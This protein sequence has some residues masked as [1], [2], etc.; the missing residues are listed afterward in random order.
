MSIIKPFLFF[1]FLVVATCSHAKALI[2]GQDIPYFYYEDKTNSLSLEL[3]LSLPQ[4]NL[5][6]SKKTLSK[7]YT[8]STFWIKFDVNDKAF[9]NNEYWFEVLPVYLDRIEFYY[10][11][12]SSN[13]WIKRSAG[14]LNNAAEWDVD[15]RAPV[16]ILPKSS[17]GYS[18]VIKVTTSSS[19]LL[20][21]RIWKEHD[22]IGYSLKDNI[23]WSF[24]FGVFSFAGMILLLLALV[25]GGR[26]F[27]ISF[28]SFFV[29]FDLFCMHGYYEWFFGKSPLH[30]QHY[31]TSLSFIAI[32]SVVLLACS[33]IIG[34]RE[35]FNKIYKVMLFI[36]Y[37]ISFQSVFVI[38]DMYF[39]VIK[40]ILFFFMLVVL[41]YFLVIYIVFIKRNLVSCIF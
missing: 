30:I 7:G 5:I 13:T 33:E 11:E 6:E 4:E 37:L 27:W 15:Y 10:K 1:S 40:N 9:S 35:R 38:F 28:F 34:L 25:L 21:V 29:Y 3:L 39:L 2:I 32:F 26:I 31:L 14:D 18:V 16:F 12:D 17:D 22:F 36:I 20:N 19:M 41:F 24:F 23:F 8:E